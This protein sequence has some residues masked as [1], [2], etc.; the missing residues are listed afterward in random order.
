MTDKSTRPECV[1]LPGEASGSY[2][3]STECV[4]IH[5]A[6]PGKS[7]LGDADQV[8]SG[9]VPS[10]ILL[11]TGM[12]MRGEKEDRLYLKAASIFMPPVA[13]AVHRYGVLRSGALFRWCQRIAVRRL[14]QRLRQYGRDTEGQA[15]RKPDII[16]HSFGAWLVG[17]VLQANPDILVG[18]IILAGSVLRP[19]FE[20]NML[21]AGGQVEAVLN[22]CGSRDLWCW[23]T[24]LFI[25]GSGPSGFRGF[26]E[27]PG[28][29]NR[30]SPRFMHTT[31]FEEGYIDDVYRSLW[32]PFLISPA[33][34][35]RELADP[36][37]A[38]VWRPLPGVLRANLPRML[39]L[40]A[41]GAGAAV[42]LMLAARFV[43]SVVS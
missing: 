8:P 35:L 1:R 33:D 10:L 3:E 24:E 22:H 13:V 17:H 41:V 21:I 42:L 34:E 31:F 7:E 37:A 38:C 5:V 43:T 18:R 39:L 30:M 36:P 19:D 14:A 29:F 32:R 11:V 15:G 20:W 16:A 4:P 9:R 26:D 40:I 12:G 27:C 28:I 2:V 6:T 25:P 23:V